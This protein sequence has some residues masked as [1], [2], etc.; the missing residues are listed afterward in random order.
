MCCCTCVF[1]CTQFV[2]SVVF[3]GSTILHKED[4]NNVYS[5]VTIRVAKSHMCLSEENSEGAYLMSLVF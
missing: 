2:R 4:E 1:A 3:L 5:N